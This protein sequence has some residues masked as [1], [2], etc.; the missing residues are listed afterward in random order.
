MKKILTALFITTVLFAAFTVAMK[1]ESDIRGG[2]DS[3][4]RPELVWILTMRGKCSG[5]LIHPQAVLSALHCYPGGPILV[6][7]GDHNIENPDGEV[8]INATEVITKIGGDIM[9]IKLPHPVLTTQFVKPLPVIS[10]TEVITEATL[11]GWGKITETFAMTLQKTAQFVS[12]Q[13]GPLI[14]TRS[15]TN[16]SALD[17]D[18]GGA[19]IANDKVVGIISYLIIYNNKIYETCSMNLVNYSERIYNILNELPRF[20]LYYFPVAGN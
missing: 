6:V 5:V 8:A 9:L 13:S 16:T 4:R 17:G 7:L 12:Y 15:A 10:T 19:L 18:S 3:E 14:C 2:E 1:A 20:H 11:Y